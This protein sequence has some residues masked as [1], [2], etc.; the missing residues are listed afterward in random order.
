MSVY[1]RK[2]GRWAV[3]IDTD[4]AEDGSR[5]RRALGTFHTKKEA[6]AAERAAI[7]A[8]VKGVDFDAGRLTV[9]EACERFIERCRS[10]GLAPAS[11]ARYK[12]LIRDLAPIRSVPL[13]RLT[14]GQV[15][16]AYQAA[17]KRGLAPKSLR[18]IHAVL[19]AVVAWAAPESPALRSLAL[20]AND[21]PGVPKTLA[22]AFDAEEVHRQFAAAA[23]TP[24]E[25]FLVLA[26][27][28]GARRSELAALRWSDIDATGRTAKIARSL[29]IDADGSV[30]A[31]GTKTATERLV[32]LNA[33]ALDA[34][35]SR[36][37][38][39]AEERLAAG[40]AYEANDLIFADPL[41][42]PWNP[43]S[44]SNAFASLAKKAKVAGR[45]HDL[46][47]S[48]ATWLLQTGTDIRTVAGIL[49]HSTPVTTL[50]TYAHVMPGAQ[51]EA[52]ERIAER[53][54]AS[55]K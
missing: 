3:R 7:D 41:G 31:K 29:S 26:V 36:R 14:H 44:I 4:R 18:A 35:K 34:L 46:R 2:S 25:A 10:K 24:W 40:A 15:S 37:V 8:R 33:V 55:G 30:T 51:G 22:R 50:G 12:E 23:E 9:G 17:A 1:K 27:C 5:Q 53:L 20:A 28:T 43:R 21:L 42:R 39:Q 52:V 38:R 49:G 13:Q 11:L 32:P 16:A 47:H 19:R 54:R 48:C 45:L 6:E